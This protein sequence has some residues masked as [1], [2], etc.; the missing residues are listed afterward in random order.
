MSDRPSSLPIHVRRT[1]VPAPD[2][3][4]GADPAVPPS[5]SNQPVTPTQ[6]ATTVGWA[7]LNTRVSLDVDKLLQAVMARRGLSKRAVVELAIRQ[8]GQS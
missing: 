4:T 1:P 7:T 5:S 3:G 2:H 6:P 8:L